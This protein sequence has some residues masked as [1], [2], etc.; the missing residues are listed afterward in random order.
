MKK[1]CNTTIL[2]LLLFILPAVFF[3]MHAQQP[4]RNMIANSQFEEGLT[5]WRKKTS[6][7]ANAEF[8]VE[9]SNPISGT[10][11]A[12]LKLLAA[13]TSGDIRDARLDY[14]LPVENGARYTVRF[15]VR[16]DRESSL[17]VEFAQNYGSREPVGL[18]RPLPTDFSGEGRY[19]KGTVKVTTEAREYVFT[20]NAVTANDWNYVFSFNFGSSNQLGAT[21]F[22]DDIKI[23]RADTGDWDGNLFPSGDM[24]NEIPASVTSGP[25][26]DFSVKIHT[27]LTTF[28]E[29]AKGEY[30]KSSKLITYE[31]PDEFPN[32]SAPLFNISIDGKYTGVYNDINA[33][34]KYVSFGYFDFT[35]GNEVEVEITSLNSFSSY[36]IL[37]EIN[38]IQ[39]TKDGN[40]I[41]F[42]T[43]KADQAITVVFDNN[44]Q[45]NTLHLF[46]NSIDTNAPTG[47]STDLVYFGRGYHNLNGSLSISRNQ[48]VY[49]AGGAV[50]DGTLKIEGGNGASINGRGML[51]KQDL[52]GVVLSVSNTNNSTLDGILVHNHRNPG[53]TVAFHLVSGV[54]VTNVNVVS[55]RYASTDGFDIVNSHNVTLKNVFVR[56]C[57]DAIAIKGLIEDAPADCP[58]NENMLFENLQL[59]NDCNNAMCLGA[60]TRASYYKNI[61]FKNID[62][63]YSYDDKGNH[64][65]LDERSVMS[66]VCLEGTYFSDILY[67][68]IRVNR[69]ERLICLTFKDS[70][71]FGSIQG[72]QS[73]NGGISG[74]T[75]KN[76][77]SASSSGS[78]IANDILLNGWSKSG[79]PSK[80]VENITFNNVVIEGTL[81]AN[82]SNSH[83]KTNS[84]VR[85]LYFNT[86]GTRSASGNEDV[87]IRSLTSTNAT[88][89]TGAWN[90]DNNN[91]LGSN[92]S[93]YVEK[94]VNTS[95]F[96]RRDFMVNVPF[97]AN[98][99]VDTEISFDVKG[100]SILGK[101][102][103][104]VVNYVN[105]ETENADVIAG[106]P[107]ITQSTKT[108][109]YN[110]TN[111]D[112]T[113]AASNSGVYNA[114]YDGRQH[115]EISF[116]EQ[117]ITPVG[118]KCWLDNVTVKELVKLQNFVVLGIPEN[119]VITDP[120]QIS[121]D[122]F[123]TPTHAPTAVV[124]SVDNGTGE[125]SITE[126]G[127]L[128]WSKNGSIVLKVSS[129]DN[130][131]VKTFPLTVGD[132]VSNG[133]LNYEDGSLV[134]PTIIKRSELIYVS[135]FLAKI[136]VIATNGRLIYNALSTN[137]INTSEWEPGIYFLNL[138]R[139]NGEVKTVKIRITN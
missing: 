44:Y 35:P 45:G 42:K 117:T 18:P 52:D 97:W 73:T 91:T 107:Q 11:S 23:A 61:T 43:N 126:N 66:I 7:N 49:I 36:K 14:Y 50:V 15:K 4:K 134:C 79:T 120:V 85:N 1:T 105:E 137:V 53:W 75:Y 72:D 109:T 103:V 24:E 127:L 70:F 119:N 136:N 57:D 32:E 100:G 12:K 20:T 55:T 40:T 58:P 76:V 74:I 59:W 39:A 60:E 21:F 104:R 78:S 17:G 114:E 19:L 34:D 68:D 27:P 62:V 51:M 102:D 113:P 67:E 123:V 88:T 41:K 31:V 13:G 99:S 108:I 84:M 33:W 80:Y 125:A 94:N 56:A 81:V 131:V 130:S 90:I 138:I 65:Q 5:N 118:F 77:T 30:T 95:S 86:G 98:E 25:I 8:S 133:K 6:N 54:D 122:E 26:E 48:Q 139:K 71:W 101:L 132:V 116:A 38:N 2:Q 29:K 10:K 115:L 111:S 112:Q 124:Y 106:L 128:T 46:A 93:L 16:A 89:S 47:S 64:T 129:P 9:E 87:A 110:R 92:K 63:L 37:P 121:I 28:E 3:E 135:E 69:C 82:A 22:I 83:I 96:G